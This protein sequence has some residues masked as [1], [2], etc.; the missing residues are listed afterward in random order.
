MPALCACA[1][2]VWRKYRSIQLS[3]PKCL[4]DPWGVIELIFAEVKLGLTIQPVL[5]TC[6]FHRRASFCKLIVQFQRHW[7]YKTTN[8]K[9]QYTPILQSA[10]QPACMLC[11]PAVNAQGA[12]A[13]GDEEPP[14]GKRVRVSGIS[15]SLSKY[16][17]LTGP[18]EHC[19]SRERRRGQGARKA[20]RKQAS[21]WRL[22]R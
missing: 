7:A 6:L 18:K 15:K 21:A 20:A 5:L 8:V 10:A 17:C 16:I 4:E 13:G 1:L 14:T 3:K 19:L 12:S 2:L 9:Q 22:R 11:R